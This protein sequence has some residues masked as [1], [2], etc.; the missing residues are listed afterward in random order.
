MTARL[1]AALEE[2]GDM[3]NVTPVL[4]RFLW[5]FLVIFAVVGLIAVLTPRMAKWID[6]FRAK[7]EKPA[8]PEDPRCAQVRGPYDMPPQ[9]PSDLPAQEESEHMQK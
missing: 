5:K 3:V 9:K 7:H 6:E 2:T 1:L 4:T 8:P